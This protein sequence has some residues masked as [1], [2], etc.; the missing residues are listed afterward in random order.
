MAIRIMQVHFDVDDTDGNGPETITIGNVSSGTS[1]AYYIFN[2]SSSTT[3][4]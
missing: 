4:L 1:Y 3:F 2:Y